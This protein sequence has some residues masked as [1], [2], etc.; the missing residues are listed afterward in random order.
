MKLGKEGTEVNRKKKEAVIG[1]TTALREKKNYA[2]I[3]R[4]SVAGERKGGR[5][6]A[7]LAGSSM[8]GERGEGGE[9]IPGSSKAECQP[10]SALL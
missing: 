6:G 8:R 7:L 4:Y 3:R 5:F 1:P 9:A 10:Y 2:A